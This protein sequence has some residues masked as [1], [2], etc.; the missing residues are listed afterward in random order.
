M[1]NKKIAY[2]VKLI[3]KGYTPY[4]FKPS[5]S[6][7]ATFDSKLTLISKDGDKKTIVFTGMEVSA[8]DKAFMDYFTSEE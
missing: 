8:A 3:E 4:Y 2:A 5:K 6:I 1:M 7:P